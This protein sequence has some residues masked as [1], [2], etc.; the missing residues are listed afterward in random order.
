MKDPRAVYLAKHGFCSAPDR[1][2][3]RPFLSS[4]RTEWRSRLLRKAIIL[5]CYIP[6]P[7]LSKI[8]TTT[9]LIPFRSSAPPPRAEALAVDPKTRR[10][11]TQQQTGVVVGAQLSIPHHTHHVQ[12]YPPPPKI[13]FPSDQRQNQ[14]ERKR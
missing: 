3:G 4:R 6:H 2:K 10:R 5:L 9:D 14:L 11:A 8:S 13:S 12:R 1:K 7:P